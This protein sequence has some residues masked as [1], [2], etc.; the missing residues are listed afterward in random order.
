MTDGGVTYRKI[1]TAFTDFALVAIHTI[2]YERK[3]YPQT[4]F[5]T[6]RKYNF[7]VHQ[8]RHPKVCEWIND[9]VNALEQELL[10]CTVA[11]V[12]VVI[13]TKT[14]RPA[15]RYVFDVSHF[16][17]ISNT[18]LDTNIERQAEDG[19]KTIALPMVN[20]EEQFRGTV[21][22]LTQ[23]G[24]NL[25]ALPSGC[26]FTLAIELKDSG[27]PPLSHPQPWIPV[28]P[29]VDVLSLNPNTEL[30]ATPIRT[31]EAGELK[32]EMWIEE[33]QDIDQHQ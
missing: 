24:S 5:L 33:V 14:N 1:V 17:I 11:R 13:F 12:A 9:A 28:Q 20:I 19:D 23:C 16:P 3:I 7:P 32:F 6:A 27:E 26:T 8:S 25:K 15:E 22:K 18:D 4:S 30:Q 21:S 31:V 10:K 2:L 29:K